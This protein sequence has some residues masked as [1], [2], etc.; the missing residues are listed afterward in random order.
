MPVIQELGKNQIDECLAEAFHRQTPVALTWRTES[1]WYSGSTKILLVTKGNLWLEYPRCEKD[2]SLEITR[3]LPVVLSFKIRHHK[4]VFNTVVETIGRMQRPVRSVVE[5]SG[6][7]HSEDKAE[8][9]ALCV[10]K[11]QKMLRIQRR[12][13]DRVDVPRN[14]SVLA[15]FW[16]GG[17]ANSPG[18][19]PDAKL[20]WEAWVMNISAGGLQV[21]TAGRVGPQLET[22]DILGV[23]IE[24]GQEFQPVLADAMLRHQATDERG[25]TVVGFQFIGLDE[26]AHGRETFQRLSRIVRAFQRIKGRR[27]VDTVA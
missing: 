20:A 21:R 23:R 19:S 6:P 16:Q 14:R 15:T 2:G 7:S 13:Y 1:N 27:R 3:A 10:P 11:P 4:H 18:E 24:P 17:L 12:A 26:S 5:A 9:R 25:V 22:G 8:V